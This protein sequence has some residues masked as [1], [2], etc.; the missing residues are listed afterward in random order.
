VVTPASKPVPA[1]DKKDRPMYA[2]TNPATGELVQEFPTLSDDEAEAAL[3][4]SAEAYRAW[5]ARTVAERAEL[6]R[7]IAD[8]HRKESETLAATVTLEMGKPIAQARAEVELAASIYEYYAEKGPA[9]LKDEE[10]DVAG[11][12][13]AVVRTAPIG[14]LLGIMPWNF[15]LYQVARFVAPN[16]LLGNT[17]LLKH[18]EGCPQ[19]S[20]A[21]A[22]T[23][24]D[25]GVPEDVY[26]S[27][28]ATHSQ[29]AAMI[30]DPHLQGVSIT[31]SERAG[32]A[33][34][35]L[36]G[37]HLKKCV[38]ELGGSDP[39]IILPGADLGAAVPAAV[40]GRFWNA[41][42]V[43]TSM[44]RTIVSDGLWDE[45]MGKFLGEVE[46]WQA[47]DPRQEDTRLG[48]MSSL[49]ARAD[50]AEVVEDAIAKGATLHAGGSV[51]D[52]PGAWYPATVLSGVTPDMR[53]YHEEIFGPVAVVHRVGS[54]DEAVEL[55]N[56]SPY[57]L[58]GAVF[59]ADEQAAEKVADRLE[60]GMVGLNMLVRSSPELPFGGVKN[61]GIG[62]ELGRFG[63]DEFANKKL[64][65]FA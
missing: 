52:G 53:A 20:L 38:L 21:I 50:V 12:G 51:P 56:S 14:P 1:E 36:A 18:A 8:L 37:Q 45:F 9:L 42:Q 49:R 7:A 26:Q 64:V 61:S 43:C 58:G 39:L 16:L 30:A 22:R 62:R 6:L 41:G 47:G 25:A 33:V 29:A 40:N 46:S 13:R 23:I 28:F 59:A 2:T 54:E 48:P 44:K 34:G 57:G 65:R 11:T 35:A 27:V 31:G 55:A 3:A 24:H 60:V 63:L 4:R 5:S 10:L 15:P 19:T 32:R 17:I